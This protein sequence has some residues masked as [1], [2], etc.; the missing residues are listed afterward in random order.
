MRVN[1]QPGLLRMAALGGVTGPMVFVGA[2]VGGAA[3]THRDY[4][5]VHD[6][7]SRLA[8]VGNNSRSVMTAGFI[9]FGVGLPMYA[10]ALRRSI[11]GPAWLCAAVTGVATLAV[12][13]TP[14]DR[15]VTTDRCHAVAAGIGYLTLAA[16]P[17]LASK[18]LRRIGHSTLARFATIAG[19]VSAV[20]L[21][22]TTTSLPTGLVQRVGLTS[23]DIWLTFCAA[24]IVR[25]TL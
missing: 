7:I 3:I 5:S 6:A 20:S 15:S 18:P 1:S 11:D 12:A 22:L 2:W 24:A 23:T 8:A 4:S 25:G 14:L 10:A 21:L 19:S 16:T 9:G 17:L 13:A